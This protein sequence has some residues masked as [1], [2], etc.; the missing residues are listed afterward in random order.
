MKKYFIFFLIG[1]VIFFAHALYTRHAI[2]GDGN[3][4]Y[5]YT[6]ALY[7]D[8]GFN[9]DPIFAHLSNFTGRNYIFSRIF[10]DTSVSPLGI[11]FNPYM[12]GTGLVWLP[13]MAVISLISGVFGL[14]ASRFDLIYELGPGITGI[15]LMLLG[16]HFLEKYLRNFFSGKTASW[17]IVALFFGSYLFYYMTFEPA[18]SH[19]P[20]FF[21]VS[22]LLWW[23]Y[24]LKINR[25]NSFFLGFLVGL[26]AIVR[27]ADVFL[28]IPVAVH[29]LRGK[30][31]LGN[32]AFGL[33]GLFLAI[34]PQLILQY[35]SF[36]SILINNYFVC[37]GCVWKFNIVH[38]AEYLFS[39]VRG[40]FVWSPIFLLGVIGL[41]KRKSWIVLSTIFVFWVI[42]SS[43]PAY[44]SAGFGQRFAF[45][46]TPYFAL[47]IAYLI[48]KRKQ[49]EKIL[50]T[51]PFIAWNFTLIVGFY[52]L[53][54]GR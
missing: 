15:I 51:I 31:K 35:L 29:L 9:F 23:T 52:I 25:V 47:G 46:I 19:Q 34:S 20:S 6:Q 45:S 11:R 3:G 18:L 32:L 21:I 49:L 16:L 42:T 30:T 48:D 26:L 2:Y 36:G 17:T 14:G 39:P 12:I 28:L 43:W 54:L 10:W 13:S 24:K 33:P 4:Y 1:I 44:L 5:S 8:H 38:F 41:I 37:E 27:I 40:L 22:F 7:F 50:Y 53:K